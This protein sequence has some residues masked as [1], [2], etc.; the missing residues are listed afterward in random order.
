[1][2]TCQALEHRAPTEAAQ[3]WLSSQ[4]P[5][6]LAL[7]PLATRSLFPYQVNKEVELDNLCVLFHF[8]NPLLPTPVF[9][10]SPCSAAILQPPPTLASQPS[11]SQHHHSADLAEVL[12][13]LQRSNQELTLISISLKSELLS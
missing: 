10:P 11:P 8:K 12:P 5:L 9:P 1:M 13:F 2:G 6:R 4:L 7:S 3:T